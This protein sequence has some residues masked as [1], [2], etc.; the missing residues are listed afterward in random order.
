MQNR[1]RQGYEFDVMY[2]IFISSTF[3]DLSEQRKIAFEA[4]LNT[5]NFPLA[6]ERFIPR[7]IS[8]REPPVSG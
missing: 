4:I 3:R 5:N 1:Q 8:D 2:Q 6:M 7:N